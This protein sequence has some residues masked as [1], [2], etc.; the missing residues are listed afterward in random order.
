MAVVEV[1]RGPARDFLNVLDRP[2]IVPGESP[3]RHQR[4]NSFP[5]KQQ[6]AAV[7][8]EQFLVKNARGY[9]GRGHLPVAINHPEVYFLIGA[10]GA[11]AE[12]LFSCERV[13]RCREPLPG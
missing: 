4:P 7:M 8:N 2:G 11:E 13:E 10:R 12:K 1:A 3:L 9:K 5:D 6:F